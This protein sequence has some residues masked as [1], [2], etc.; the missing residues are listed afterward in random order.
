M[1]IEEVDNFTIFFNELTLGV[2][3]GLLKGLEKYLLGQLSL[4]LV[5]QFV[6]EFRDLALIG[7]TFQSK[8]FM[9]RGEG[10]DFGP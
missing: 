9:V 6:L 5:D 7:C 2:E 3:E 8:V 4:I 1:S 10:E